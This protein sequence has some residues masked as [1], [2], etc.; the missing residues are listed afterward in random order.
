VL[1]LLATL[2]QL[3]QKNNLLKIIEKEQQ[4]N[5]EL[6]EE[7]NALS[8][9][10]EVK[11]AV[12]FATKSRESNQLINEKALTDAK[13]ILE[14]AEREANQIKIN[15][16]VEVENIINDAKKRNEELLYQSK[17]TLEKAQ[18]EAT[19]I[20]NDANNNAKNIINAAS[21]RNE[22]LLHQSKTTLE[23]AKQD[24]IQIKNNADIAADNIRKEANKNAKEIKEKSQLILISANNKSQEIIINA[25]KKAEEI[26][27]ESYR[28][29]QE[30]EHLKKST[31]AIKNV[32]ESYGYA[33]IK[34]THSIL[35]ELAE[36]YGFHEIGQQLKQAR[37]YSRLL[38]DTNQAAICDYVER[39]RKETAIRFVIDA[40]NG[41]VDS[42]LSKIKTTNVGILEQQILDSFSIVNLNGSAFRNARITEQFLSARTL[43]LKWAVA[44]YALKEK[45]KEEQRLIKEKMR[46]EEK[47]RKEIERALKESAREEESLQKAIAKIQ[48][49]F[50]KANEMQRAQYEEKLAELQA[51]LIDAESRN[52]RA[53]SM[54][55]QTKAGYVYII[56]NIGSFGENIFKIGM[57]RRLEPLDRIREL[58]GASV[59]FK[60]DVHAMIWSIDA[61]NLERALHKKFVYSQINKI[62]PRKEFF[63]IPIFELK[64]A[65]QEVGIEVTW[66]MTALASEYRES[67]VI[68]QSL[69]ENPKLAEEWLN[70]QFKY[71]RT[72]EIFE[73]ED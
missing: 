28:A 2:I 5:S 72:E 51:K 56:S 47:A 12:E 32:I 53:L 59:P 70:N 37:E 42:I 48:G 30:F 25:N 52:Q 36:K 54:A 58:G 39:N 20:K 31:S 24:A 38:I 49:Q 34:P 19:Q 11:D 33:Y 62:N 10:K 67:L 17:N 16:S 61:P 69:K 22:E 8:I 57:T 43:E 60:F 29:L 27:G 73:V 23:R 18:Q 46:E 41:K 65:I 13:N 68:E 45:E 14:N 6:N 1:L 21:K 44:I 7:L 4:K 63:K 26:A 9:F 40:F 35:D 64:K 71:E 15:A 55:Q 66:T 50:A 3:F